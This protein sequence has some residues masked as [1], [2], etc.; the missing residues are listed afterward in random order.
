MTAA[1]VPT[2]AGKK[3]GFAPRQRVLNAKAFD[4]VYAIRQRVVDDIFSVNVARNEV[5][6]ARL[7]LSVSTKSVG[8]SVARN[9]VKRQVRESFRLI[10]AK[11]PPIDVVVGT[12]N[13][14]R[15]AHNAR[16]RESLDKHWQEIKKR[17]GVS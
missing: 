14:A 2:A 3:L 13:G 1:T 12:R 17:C 8:N 6:F 9:R 15:T 5:G 11:L 10:A 16:L 4:A 7:G